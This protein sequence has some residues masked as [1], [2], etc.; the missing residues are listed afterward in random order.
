[1]LRRGSS[2]IF[3]GALLLAAHLPGIAHAQVYSDATLELSATG[4]AGARSCTAILKPKQ[5][6]GD[7]PRLVLTTG[8][9]AELSFGIVGGEQLQNVV[10]VQN[11][12]R[13][14]F[15]AATKIASERFL[16]TDIG[17][18]LRSG[19]LFFITAKRN[20]KFVSAR[21]EGID[22]D[23]VL[24][25]IE[26]HC[27]FDAESLMRDTSA[28]EQRERSLSLSAIDLKRI[29]WAL[30]KKYSNSC[31]EPDT[32]FLLSPNDRGY[33]RRYTAESGL[34]VSRYLTSDSA[35]RLSAAGAATER[36]CKPAATA[37]PPST[38]AAPPP[39]TT[40]DSRGY[41]TF[42][43]CNRSNVVIALAVS[44]HETPSDEGFVVEGWWI[45][46][47]SQCGTRRY[48]KGWFYFY[49]EQRG[50]GGKR[51]WGR[52]D[53]KL[54][55]MYPGPF[56]RKNTTGFTCEEKL[57]K[58]FYSVFIKPDQNDYSFTLNP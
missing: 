50:S 19:Q 1:M 10:I 2:L 9:L 58:G 52:N 22:F 51:F 35:Q 11:N 4:S 27:P 15:A 26:Q 57:L 55:V 46:E 36:E 3:A 54:C 38:P 24:Q 39:A 31:A 20:D 45:I 16:A 47:P 37:P 28:R 56:T 49:G 7:A 43:I 17:K 12:L 30:N 6:L 5:T 41:F 34:P 8:W 29:R 32:R 33:L 53:T 25:K 14:P 18:A 13:R 40:S 44:H 21:Y 42:R 48:P 23:G